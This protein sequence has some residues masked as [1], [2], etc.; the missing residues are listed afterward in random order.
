MKHL[1]MRRIPSGTFAMGSNTFYEDERPVRE[2]AVNSFW[3]D[4]IPV[5]NAQFAR[6]VK[7]TGYVTFAEIAPDPADYPDMDAALAKPGSIVFTPPTGPVALAGDPV[8]WQFVVGA[9]WRHPTGPHST[10]DALGR[11]PVVHI[12]LSDAKAYAAWSGKE[13]PSEAQWEYAARGGLHGADYAWGSDFMPDG[14]RMAKTWDG[15]FPW[16]NAARAGLERTS[17]V[18][19]YPANGYRLYDMIGNVWEWTTDPYIVNA[20][21]SDIRRCCGGAP[22]LAVTDRYIAKGG[23]HLCAPEYCQ[24]YRPAARWPQPVDTTASHIGFRCIV[25]D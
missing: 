11:H 1:G 14:R 25:R 12:A 19:S 10:I 3:I 22:A 4:E 20:R 17:P 24:R 15:L 5:T 8:W 2:V 7:A 21:V 13:L 6:F 9:D 23:S 16:H 18:K